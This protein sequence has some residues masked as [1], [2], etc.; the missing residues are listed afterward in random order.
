MATALLLLLLL[1]LLLSAHSTGASDFVIVDGTIGDLATKV[2]K[3]N[4]TGEFAE[5]VVTSGGRT[6]AL[7]LFSRRFGRVHQV[8]QSHEESD[9]NA[10]AASIRNNVHWAGCPLLPFANRIA[11]GTY[12]FQGEKYYLPQNENSSVRSDAL[13]GFLCNRTLKVVSATAGN[14]YASLTLGYNFTGKDTPGWPW[15]L[16]IEINYALTARH[17]LRITTRAFNPSSSG[18]AVPFYHSWHPY[19]KVSSVA[20]A[21]VAFD[22]SCAGWNHL[23][24]P[25]GAPRA[26]SLIPTG[27]TEA[28]SKSFIDGKSSIG[29]TDS[30]PTY[31]DDEFKSLATGTLFCGS[32]TS[33]MLEHTVFDPATKAKVVL[34]ADRSQYRAVQI[35]TGARETFPEQWSAI[36]LEPMSAL[37]DAYNNGDGL[38]ILSAGETFQ[39]TFGLRVE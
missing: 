29:G 25:P 39:G 3:N 37:A 8:L 10:R 9:E 11:N 20:N 36:A 27:K 7:Y 23:I 12:T 18:Q 26:G 28:A 30:K 17:S 22:A 33:S 32:N 6:E 31:Y 2:L 35:F 13:H 14:D 38:T 16:S 24:M 1:A 19:I 34:F 21:I 5:I 4:E 15:P